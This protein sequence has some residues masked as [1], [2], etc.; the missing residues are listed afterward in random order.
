VSYRDAV[1]AIR[2]GLVD[3]VGDCEPWQR[4]LVDEVQLSPAPL[5]CWYVFQE[6]G[7]VPNIV[8]RR[9]KFDE[10][11]A[12]HGLHAAGLD[13]QREARAAAAVARPTMICRK[14]ALEIEYAKRLF[15]GYSEIYEPGEPWLPIEPLSDIGDEDFNS[16]WLEGKSE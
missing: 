2:N 8:A 11:P 14:A 16:Y 3:I 1:E 12:T 4:E 10:L 7:G 5:Q 6:K 15:A 13:E 9:F